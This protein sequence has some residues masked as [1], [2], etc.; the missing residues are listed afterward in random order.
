LSLS[1]VGEE[2]DRDVFNLGGQ[3]VLIFEFEVGD[4]VGYAAR[5]VLNDE[6]FVVKLIVGDGADVFAV[7]PV[8]LKLPHD[9]LVLALFD[10]GLVLDSAEDGVKEADRGIVGRRLYMVDLTL[11]SVFSQNCQLVIKDTSIIQIQ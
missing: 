6:D 11:Q 2:I 3:L 9:I 10:A 8:G 1:H 5:G 4:V 7:G